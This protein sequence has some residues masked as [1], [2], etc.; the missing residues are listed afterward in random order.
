M[1][2]DQSLASLTLY[3]AAPNEFTVAFLLNILSDRV[4]TSAAAHRRAPVRPMARSIAFPFFGTERTDA[5]IVFAEVR[6]FEID[7]IVFGRSSKTTV[8]RSQLTEPTLVSNFDSTVVL[9]LQIGTNFT[10]CR[11][12]LIASAETREQ[13][14]Q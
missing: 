2:L 10:K 12:L 3:R 11:Q 13:R 4:V 7:Q 5:S 14:R 1:N 9:L 6:F 8:A